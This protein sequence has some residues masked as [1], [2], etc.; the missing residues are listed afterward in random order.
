M[1]SPITHDPLPATCI[2]CITAFPDLLRSRKDKN[3]FDLPLI[4]DDVFQTKIQKNASVDFITEQ[5]DPKLAQSQP[6]NALGYP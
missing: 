5:T 6:Q 1:P 2:Y 4:I 3:T